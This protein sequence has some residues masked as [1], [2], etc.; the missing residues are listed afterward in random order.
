[1]RVLLLIFFYHFSLYA[2]SQELD[3]VK[4][5]RSKR[6][7]LT[8]YPKPAPPPEKKAFVVITSGIDSLG[9]DAWEKEWTAYVEEQSREI[10]AKVLQRDST[11]TIYKVMIEFSVKEDGSLEDLGISCDPPN[12]LIVKEC[13][14]MALNAPKKKSASRWLRTKGEYVRMRVKQPVDIKLAQ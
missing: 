10:A 8:K 1:M 4:R 13:S 7:S 14:K 3:T 12:D 2:F 11:P 6:V 9:K 5:N